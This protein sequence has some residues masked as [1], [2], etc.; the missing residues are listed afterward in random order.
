MG[1]GSTAT[2]I[3]NEPDEIYSQDGISQ[4]TP[5]LLRRYYCLCNKHIEIRPNSLP[6]P[7]PNP[8]SKYG[9]KTI[10]RTFL[11]AFVFSFGVLQHGSSYSRDSQP[12]ASP[13]P[14]YFFLC[15]LLPLR[16]TRWCEA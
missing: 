10:L 12:L 14:S 2:T 1:K 8:P 11:V 13:N 4:M 5:F 9:F 16:L 6:H 15:C 3:G 7:L